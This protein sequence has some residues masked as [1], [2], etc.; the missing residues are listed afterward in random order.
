MNLLHPDLL[1]PWQRFMAQV[2]GWQYARIWVKGKAGHCY[3]MTVRVRDTSEATQ[4]HGLTRI[5]YAQ[6]EDRAMMY[7]TTEPAHLLDFQHFMLTER[8]EP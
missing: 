5:F 2:F 8:P 6:T 1:T 4:V 7:S 3:Y